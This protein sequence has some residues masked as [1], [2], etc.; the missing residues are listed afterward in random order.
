MQLFLDCLPC[1]MRQ[2][3]EAARIASTDE[4]TQEIIMDEALVVLA[5]HRDFGSAPELAQ[6][7][8]QIVQR[9]S[10]LADPYREIKSRDMQAALRLEPLLANFAEAGTDTLFRCLKVS[11]T[12]NVMDT[13]LYLDLDIE[14]CVARE[15]DKSFTRCDLATFEEDL[16]TATTVLIVGD[17]AGEAVFDKVLA[18]ELA[19][20]HEV[21]FAVRGRPIINDVTAEDA[22]LVG[23]DAHA[24]VISTGCSAPGAILSACSD[25]FRATF[26]RADL[27]ISKGQGN[28]EALSD[29]PRPMYYL[30]KAKCPKIAHALGVAVGDYVFTGAQVAVAEA[31]Q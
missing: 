30:L 15:L 2:V 12:G 31:P 29:V 21:T 23:M 28:F 14:S 8:H 6:A 19:R 13:A 18:R 9:R 16:A 25:D 11:A 24:T 3:L 1:L 26:D 17:N 7:M 10:G 22:R 27:V 20:T 4:A 5:Q